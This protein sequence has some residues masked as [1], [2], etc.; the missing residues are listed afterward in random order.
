MTIVWNEGVIDA[1]EREQA[2]RLD[3]IVAQ[4]LYV[5]CGQHN[6]VPKVGPD[7]EDAADAHDEGESAS[8]KLS[9]WHYCAGSADGNVTLLVCS[10]TRQSCADIEC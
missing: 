4:C 2:Q 7:S 5:C 8:G 1:A 6:V 10:L 3:S 9:R